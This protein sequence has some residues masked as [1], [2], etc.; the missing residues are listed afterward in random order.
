MKIK[1]SVLIPVYNESDVL[2]TNLHKIIKE[3]R[4]FRSPFEIIIVDDNSKDDT[5]IIGKRLQRTIKQIKYVRFNVGPSRRENL[6]KAMKV[7]KGQILIYMDIDLAVH[8]RYLNNL[9][10]DSYKWD[11]V[12][13]SRYLKGSKVKRTLLRRMISNVYNNFMKFWFSS[14]VKDHQCGFK[15]FRKSV[16]LPLIFEMGYDKKLVRG[17]FWDAELLIRAQRKGHKIKEIPVRWVRGKSSSF[18]L[19][20]ELR[21]VP[22]VFKLRGK[23]R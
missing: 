21:M 10:R 9:I 4:K 2:E 12:V 19:K 13:G 1:F 8:P 18:S 11:I 14:E 15:A 5:P 16:V 23:L 3:M 6:A 17:W 7:A 22:Y 20:R